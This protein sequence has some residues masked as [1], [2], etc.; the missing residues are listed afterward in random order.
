MV[1]ISATYSNAK[2]LNLGL[3]I[4]LVTIFFRNISW[5]LLTSL[6]NMAFRVSYRCEPE[7]GLDKE[8]STSSD[9]DDVQDDRAEQRIGCLV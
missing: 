3:K 6:I 2:R 1:G 5:E 8:S 7:Y 9:E 4:L